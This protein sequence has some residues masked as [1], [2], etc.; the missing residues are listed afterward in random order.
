[1]KKHLFILAFLF[2]TLS[3]PAQN[4]QQ[5][6]VGNARFT[7]LTPELI[8]MEWAA[9]ST[10]EDNASLAFINRNLL[11]VPYVKVKESKTDLTIATG[12]LT[13]NYKK[14]ERFNEKNLSITFRLNKKP[15]TWRPGMKDTANLKGT[16]RTLDGREGW[17]DD[18]LEQGIL[19]RAGWALVDDSQ[20]PLLLPDDRWGHWVAPRDTTAERLDW[21][22]FGYGHEYKKALY[23][24]TQAA[25]KIPM[26]PKFAFGYWWSRYWQYTDNELKDLVKT[27][28]SLDIPLDVL[29]IDMDWHKT[30]GL[31]LHNTVRDA[32]GERKGWTGYTWDRNAFPAPERFFEWAKSEHLKT[33][34]NLHPAAGIQP[35]EDVYERFAHV[36]GW[37]TSGR[38]YIPFAID[39]KKWANTYFDAVL[40]PIEKQGVD[41]WWL[42]WQQ[43]QNSRNVKGLTNTFWLNHTFFNDMKRQGGRRPLLFHR[44]GGLGNH[45]YQIG[46]SGDAYITWGSLSFQPYFTATAANVGYGYWSHDIGGHYGGRG[47][48]P[49]LYLRWL[50]YGVFSPILRTHSTKSAEIERRIWKYPGH[51][52]YMRDALHLRYR[53]APYIYNAAR[54][55]YDTGV[56]LCRPM[57]YDYPETDYAYTQKGQY[58]FGDNLLVAPVTTPADTVTGLSEVALWLPPGTWYE[59]STGALLDGGNQL[60]KRRFI[61][62]E[63]P[64]YAKAGSIIPMNPATVRNLQTRCDTLSLFFV[65]GGDGNLTYYEDDET[66]DDYAA[67][68]AFT[69]IKKETAASGERITIT[70]APREGSYNGMS[71]SR[72]YEILLPLHFPPAVVEVNGTP[73]SFTYD[74]YGLETKIVTEKL[75]CNTQ[76]VIMV[77]YDKEMLAQKSLLDNKSKRFRR[78]VPVTEEFKYLSAAYDHICNLT[79][80]YL[81]V[82]QTPSY[83]SANPNVV[84][85]RKRVKLMHG[86]LNRRGVAYTTLQSR[87]DYR[88]VGNPTLGCPCIP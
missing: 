29:I 34:L 82:A 78:F 25:G 50:Q 63:I 7:I 21:Y 56:S 10:F 38:K 35:F 6:P 37:D 59:M 24:F 73:V 58:F 84:N 66:T 43:Y 20:R 41:F 69:K 5:V 47:N 65:P 53:L 4:T 19:S 60:L 77:D 27:M 1:M 28:K 45:R 14:G 46:F 30:W 15:V 44:W 8:R 72:A 54:Q 87:R 3:L 48:D 9:D 22:F 79:D 62:S 11:V 57:Y 88:S 61:M 39:N 33:A 52:L 71:G 64:Y 36:Y 12:K 67:R 26:P 75:S 85:L 76:M 32:S 49:E 42:D 81:D 55:A 68:H 31:S 83:I 23:D 80:G 86:E 74:G 2:C 40:H 17:Q 16:M 51:F 13:L 70:I 18:K